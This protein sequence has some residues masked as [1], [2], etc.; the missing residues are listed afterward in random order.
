M[1]ETVLGDAGQSVNPYG[2][3]TAETIQK[4]LTAS[5]IMKLCKSYRST[6][7]ITDLRKDSS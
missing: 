5:E 3:S 1:P 2:S 7:E 6:F 4:S